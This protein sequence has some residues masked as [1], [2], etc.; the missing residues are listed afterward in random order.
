MRVSHAHLYVSRTS[1]SPIHGNSVDGFFGS[2]ARLR[3]YQRRFLRPR[4]HFSAFFELHIFSFAPFQISVIFQ[5]LRTERRKNR[6]PN[7]R[8]SES[9]TA[10]LFCGF[11]QTVLEQEVLRL[12]VAVA[13]VHAVDVGHRPEHLLQKHSGLRL[14]EG[15]AQVLFSQNF[16]RI[17]SKFRQILAKFP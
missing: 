5:N 3:L 10:A 6:R 13:D 8:E 11:S 14:G 1:Y 15:P 12:E 2:D 9:R 17:L 7:Y 4:S 16:V